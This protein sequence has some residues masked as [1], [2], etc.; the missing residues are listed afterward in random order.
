[1]MSIKI[2]VLP[3]SRDYMSCAGSSLNHST[4]S[5]RLIWLRKAHPGVSDDLLIRYYFSF[6]SHGILLNRFSL[7]I[8]T[9]LVAEEQLDCN[10]NE[11]CIEEFIKRYP[12]AP[13]LLRFS[14]VGFSADGQ[15]AM[16]EYSY[17]F[18]PLCSHGGTVLMEKK[19]GR[20]HVRENFGGWTS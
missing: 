17:E 6:L 7:P 8:P 13:G 5:E 1:M 19:S 20:W 4:A 18:C 16:F 14:H 15:Q 12:S 10:K 3:I 9:V 2:T 11:W